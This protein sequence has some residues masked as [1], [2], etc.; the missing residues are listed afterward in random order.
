MANPFETA[1][2]AL[3]SKGI[4]GGLLAMLALILSMSGLDKKLGLDAQGVTEI[5]LQ[6]LTALGI[7]WSVIGRFTARTVLVATQKEADAINA[8]AVAKAQSLISTR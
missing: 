8:A 2:A 6:V 3:S 5:I 1:K 4:Q 7:F